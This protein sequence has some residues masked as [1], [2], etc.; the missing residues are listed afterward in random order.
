M[1]IGLQTAR[2]HQSC[3]T[4]STRRWQSIVTGQG[5]VIVDVIRR[6]GGH[7]GRVLVSQVVVSTI[8]THCMVR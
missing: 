7:N 6:K 1:S 2:L 3:L 8:A 5:H 4:F